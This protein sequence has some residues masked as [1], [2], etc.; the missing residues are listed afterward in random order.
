MLLSP[1]IPL[2]FMGEEYG[3]TAPFLYFIEHGSPALIDSV[4]AGRKREYAAIERTEEPPDPQAEE[5]FTRSRLDW[6]RRERPDGERLLTLYR[7]LLSL[8]RE[9]PALRPG[10]S[11]THVQGA[12]EWFTALRVIPLQHDGDDVARSRRAVF[13]AF[14]LCAHPL[15]V[16]VRADAIGEWNL[17]LCTDA[18]GYGGAGA[19]PQRI[20]AE[21]T[22]LGPTDEPK[23][24]M[25]PALAESGIRTIR[26]PAWS[27]AVYIR[28]FAA[29]DGA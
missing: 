12:P 1:Y 4:R 9:E 11:E 24:L 15:N 19:L 28:D 17:R 3:E 20:P 7:D 13:C 10:A 2:L 6:S 5:T 21:K 16:P 22:P 25:G 8:R 14:N 29:V 27:A 18:I 23:R 26:L